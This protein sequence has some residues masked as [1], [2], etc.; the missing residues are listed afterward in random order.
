[1]FSIPENFKFGE[2]IGQTL[3]SISVQQNMLQLDFGRMDSM[4]KGKYVDYARI[5]IEQG[6]RWEW[7]SQVE[8]FTQ[9]SGPR[10][11][12]EAA[13]ILGALVNKSLT[14]VEP[15]ATQELQLTFSTGVRII[16]LVGELES[17]HFNSNQGSFT[18]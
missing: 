5:R 15:L 12:T 10:D 13:G 6:V 2:L 7:N 16:L 17:Y 11:L 3:I 4:D 14:A 18:V 9:T 1:M 8:L